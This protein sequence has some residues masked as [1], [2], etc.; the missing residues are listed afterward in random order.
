MYIDPGHGHTITWYRF[1]QY[2]KNFIIPIILYQFEKDPF[3]LII[4]YDIYR[5]LDIYCEIFGTSTYDEGHTSLPVHLRHMNECRIF[6]NINS[7]TFYYIPLKYSFY[8]WLYFWLAPFELS[9][10][11]SLYQIQHFQRQS[12]VL[13]SHTY[14]K[15]RLLARNGK[16]QHHGND[17][18]N[19]TMALMRIRRHLPATDCWKF[20]E[21]LENLEW[22][23][24]LFYCKWKVDFF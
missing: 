21:Y 15:P 5:L 8:D 17:V 2:F 11:R 18:A 4:L 22:Q 9:N 19:Q 13:I 1:W 12:N 20:V 16:W 3:C 24:S 7:V 23:Y 14:A 6:H 10:D